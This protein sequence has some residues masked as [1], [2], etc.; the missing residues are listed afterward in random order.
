MRQAEL[1]PGLTPQPRLPAGFAYQP[2]LLTPQQ[3]AELI[4][5]VQRL[6]LREAQY[7][8]YTAKRRIISYGA[9]YDFESNELLPA[10]QI[11]EFLLPLRE[12]VCEWARIAP[13][14]VEH[15]LVAEYAAGTQLGWHRDVPQ[16]GQIVGVSLA[17]SCRMRL[18]PYPPPAGRSRDAIA[19]TLEPR[20]VYAMRGEARWKWQHA[21]SPTKQLRYSITFRTIVRS[22][23]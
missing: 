14:E 10:G 12:R 1:F 15:A 18:R 13:A 3:E 4:A 21:I 5:W 20:S 8:Q 19:L 11:P 2:E 6:P 7:K 9:S 22:G 23:D 16:F 17:S